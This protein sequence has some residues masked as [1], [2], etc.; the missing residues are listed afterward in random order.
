MDIFLMAR[1]WRKKTILRPYLVVWICV[2]HKKVTQLDT[3]SNE[4]CFKNER[5]ILA[6]AL[7]LS[8]LH[9][10]L[11][12]KYECTRNHSICTYVIQTGNRPKGRGI[13]AFCTTQWSNSPFNNNDRFVYSL[14]RLMDGGATNFWAVGGPQL[15]TMHCNYLSI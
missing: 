6:L 14:K 3:L 1:R 5:E 7:N 4:L 2:C 8:K 12:C 15:Y 9:N 11:L 10:K 13:T